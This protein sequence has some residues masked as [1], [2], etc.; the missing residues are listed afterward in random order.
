[1]TLGH[2]GKATKSRKTHRYASIRGTTSEH[3]HKRQRKKSQNFLCRH[4]PRVN[5]TVEKN[6]QEGG[7]GSKT[8]PGF[9]SVRERVGC[10]TRYR[11]WH[12]QHLQPLIPDNKDKQPKVD[13]LAKL[14]QL[15]SKRCFG[16]FLVH[17][18]PI[19]TRKIFP[20]LDYRYALTDQN[21]TTVCGLTRHVDNYPSLENYTSCA[22]VRE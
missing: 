19:V 3:K 18:V 4:V 17:N 11:T 9:A 1:M 7:D 12:V 15:N 20:P 22:I 16:K 2:N 6:R 14:K 13:H 5:M 10:S 8:S 21:M